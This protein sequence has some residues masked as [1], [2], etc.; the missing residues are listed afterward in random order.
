MLSSCHVLYTINIHYM[1]SCT[2]LILDYPSILFIPIVLRILGYVL[3]IL[4]FALYSS[5]YNPTGNILPPF[6]L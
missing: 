2:H 4:L 1:Y 6:D 5:S 3:H